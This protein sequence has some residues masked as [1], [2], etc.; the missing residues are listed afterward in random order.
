MFS[1]SVSQGTDLPS[2]REGLINIDRAK[3][4]KGAEHKRGKRR[5]GEIGGAI[6]LRTENG[7][8]EKEKERVKRG[9]S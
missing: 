2:D 8:K 5:N 3:T 7:R 6:E 9:K 1:W 4:E